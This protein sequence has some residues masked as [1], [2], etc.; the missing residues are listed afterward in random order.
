V[1]FSQ[2]NSR[3]FASASASF[4]TAMTRF[5]VECFFVMVRFFVERTPTPFRANLGASH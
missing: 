4:K 3:I 1:L 2:K 5:S